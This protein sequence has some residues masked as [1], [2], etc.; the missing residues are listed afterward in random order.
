MQDCNLAIKMIKEVFKEHCIPTE[1][2]KAY[3]HLPFHALCQKAIS[4]LQS[5]AK[6]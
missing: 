1:Y 5:A 6:L 3:E 2:K 4:L